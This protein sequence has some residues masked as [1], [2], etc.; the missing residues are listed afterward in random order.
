MAPSHH[1]SGGGGGG[2]GARRRRAAVKLLT[3]AATCVGAFFVYEH[4]FNHGH[5]AEDVHR[6]EHGIEHAAHQ[7]HDGGEDFFRT[8]SFH[9]QHHQQHQHQHRGEEE[10][11]EVVRGGDDGDATTRGGDGVGVEEDGE[12]GTGT[13]RRGN[14]DDAR[15][16]VGAEEGDGAAIGATAEHAA[17]VEVLGEEVH[18]K[19][20][21]HLEAAARADSDSP[22]PSPDA[23]PLPPPPPPPPPPASPPPPEPPAPAEE[24]E[25]VPQPPAEEEGMEQQQQHVEEEQQHHYSFLQ[26]ANHFLGLD[27]HAPEEKEEEKE[28]EVVEYVAPAWPPEFPTP[29]PARPSSAGR[30]VAKGF[31]KG[32]TQRSGTKGDTTQGGTPKAGTHVCS[33]EYIKE[34]PPIRE[35][36][37]GTREG[38]E[39]DRATKPYV[40]A[41]VH[42]ESP[43]ATDSSL[44]SKFGDVPKALLPRSSAAILRGT[45]AFKRW[46]RCAVVGNSG[47]LLRT[48]YGAEID[49]HDV[50]MR[51]NQAPTHSY[52]KHVGRRTTHRLLNRLWTL[53]YQ[54]YK[55]LSG[56]YRRFAKRWPLEKGVTLISSR[57]N[58]DNF[59]SLAEYLAKTWRR[60]DVTALV[61]NRALVSRA[62]AM[63]KDFRHC[64][65]RKLRRK[66]A[67]GNTAS[68][69]MVAV[70]ILRELCHEVR[71]CRTS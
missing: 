39:E 52:E 40:T 43:F 50:V 57:T 53:A 4:L 61:M 21:S 22:P 10:G 64:V 68:S 18:R 19:V 69:G 11:R 37:A 44:R 62:E 45:S 58:S 2:G 49:A 70:V 51:I 46:G 26:S 54:D 29:S 38:E 31:T 59:V 63:I 66:F 47:H 35:C 8:F 71:G 30:V 13:Q 28:E 27:R 3:A 67:G 7:L 15:V 24:E 33:S 55:G 5:W 16:A 9:E 56:M 41:F 32:D 12:E 60:R 6:V 1:R 65:E 34:I 20:P 17:E 42:A 14:H 25:P 48:A 23:P 36:C